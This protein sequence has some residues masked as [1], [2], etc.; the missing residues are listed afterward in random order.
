[1]PKRVLVVDD[2]RG[3][4]DTLK[5]ILTLS[6]YDCAVA[7]TASD[8]LKVVNSFGPHLVITDVIMPGMNGI[9][10]ASELRTSHPFLPVILLSG[11]ALSQELLAQAD[12]SLGP[13]LLL[14]KPFSP[15]QMLRVVAEL[16]GTMRSTA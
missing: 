3:V 10:L 2:E 12:E 9:D 5:T 4:D 13:V 7:Y 8:A 6:G 15:R 11:N 1:V 14:P 16:T